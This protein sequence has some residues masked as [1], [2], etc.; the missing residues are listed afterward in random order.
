VLGKGI[1]GQGE[2][3]GGNRENEGGGALENRG[4]RT[5]LLCGEGHKLKRKA[6]RVVVRVYNV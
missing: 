6:C 4:G 2:R 3:E 5:S 1:L